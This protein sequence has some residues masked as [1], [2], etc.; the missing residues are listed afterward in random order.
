MQSAPRGGDPLNLSN[1]NQAMHSPNTLI[2]AFHG[3]H[4]ETEAANIRNQHYTSNASGKNHGT[5]SGISRV[6]DN[7]LINSGG[8][9]MGQ[10]HKGKASRMLPTAN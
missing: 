6:R 8:L 4:S 2:K 3:A 1:N 7:L 10:N 5:T 9:A